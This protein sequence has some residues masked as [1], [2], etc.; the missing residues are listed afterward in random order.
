MVC[1]FWG[2]YIKI[3]PL[4]FSPSWKEGEKGKFWTKI[5]NMEYFDNYSIILE[6]ESYHFPPIPPIVGSECFAFVRIIACVSRGFKHKETPYN[7]KRTSAH[8][9]HRR[10]ENLSNFASLHK[11]RFSWLR[12]YIIRLKRCFASQNVFKNEALPQTPIGFFKD[13][14]V[15][16]SATPPVQSRCSRITHLLRNAS[17]YGQTSY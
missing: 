4:L 11:D 13:R 9:P 5:G 3:P 14:I 15:R 1:I 16:S 10:H 2:K 8:A 17:H 6:G 12:C 7:P